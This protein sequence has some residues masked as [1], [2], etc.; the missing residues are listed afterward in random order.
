MDTKPFLAA[1][2]LCP[3]REQLLLDA[4]NSLKEC[5]R[6]NIE[7][8]VVV[9]NGN[10]NDQIYLK[11]YDDLARTFLGIHLLECKEH[12]SISKLWNMLIN[13]SIHIQSQYTLLFNDDIL[14]KD[15]DF[16]AKT[17]E[18][19]NEYPVVHLTEAWSA[20][21]VNNEFIKELG[22]FDEGLLYSFEDITFHVEALQAGYDNF[23]YRFHPHLVK[24]LSCPIGRSLDSESKWMKSAEHFLSRWDIGVGNIGPQDL[25]RMLITGDFDKLDRKSFKLK[26]PKEL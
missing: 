1:F 11:L 26:R 5:N 8:I 7:E 4:L 23:E 2:I 17:L 19:H 15:K 14:F 16:L 13:K 10:T 22:W 12:I 20:A 9:Y 18:K 3:G 21:S 6:E 25:Y 24:H